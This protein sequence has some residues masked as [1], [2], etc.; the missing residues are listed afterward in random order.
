M[1]FTTLALLWIL[2][3]SV[4][5]KLY[6]LVQNHPEIPAKKPTPRGVFPD[7][8]IC[9]QDKILQNAYVDIAY[10]HATYDDLVTRAE[11]LQMRRTELGETLFSDYFD[12]F[13]TYQNNNSR[14]YWEFDAGH[15]DYPEGYV[16]GDLQLT[17]E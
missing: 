12:N 16:I 2:L 13:M 1:S 11:T 14:K 5:E 3:V 4:P 15:N 17:Q 6:L 7:L 10:A 8:Q 9:H